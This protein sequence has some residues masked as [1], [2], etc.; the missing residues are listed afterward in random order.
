VPSKIIL[1]LAPTFFGGVALSETNNLIEAISKATDNLHRESSFKG[2]L[3]TF[4]YNLKEICRI[5]NYSAIQFNNENSLKNISLKADQLDRVPQEALSEFKQFV[6]QDPEAL[7]DLQQGMV[8]AELA[9]KQYYICSIPNPATEDQNCFVIW[10]FTKLDK[11]EETVANLLVGQLQRESAWY[12][13]LESTQSQLYRDELTGLYNNRYF[14]IAIDNEL[15]R[16]G[17]F[18]INF[19]LLFIDLDDFKPINDNHG[20]MSGSSVLCQVADEIRDAI[21]E[22]DI[23]I[24]YGGDEFVVVLLGASSSKGQLVAERIRKKIATRAYRMQDGLTDHVTASIGVAAYPE[25]GK[26]REDLLKIADKMM[27]KCKKLGKNR[28]SMIEHPRIED[29]KARTKHD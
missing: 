1:N 7:V 21:R 15:R 20:H 8:T 18:D 24:R 12:Q 23:A 16:A 2:L 26:T 6:K 14:E 17:R 4:G 9:G 19:C 11:T 29:E 28:V 22:V 25:H 5:E 27:Y 13:K 3:R 10:N